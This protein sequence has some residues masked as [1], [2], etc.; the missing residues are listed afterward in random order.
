MMRNIYKIV[1]VRNDGTILRYIKVF[2]GPKAIEKYKEYLRHSDAYY[3]DT[4]IEAVRSLSDVAMI[5]CMN[6]SVQSMF[7]I[8][9]MLGDLKHKKDDDEHEHHHH[10]N[11]NNEDNDEEEDILDGI[12]SEEDSDNDEGNDNS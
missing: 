5:D 11:D 1:R 6:N 9:S 8:F 12:W 7:E 2:D 3:R 10:H 4:K